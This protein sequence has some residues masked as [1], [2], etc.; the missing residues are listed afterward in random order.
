MKRILGI[1]LMMALLVTV[2]GCSGASVE[3]PE[4]QEMVVIEEAVEAPDMEEVTE[5]RQNTE[6]EKQGQADIFGKV[7]RIVGNE[8]TVQLV[9]MP[10]ISG[11]IEEG[12]EGGQNARA[13]GGNKQEPKYTGETKQIIIPVG[14]PIASRAREGQEILDLSD[15]VSGSMIM[16]WTDESGEPNKIQIMGAR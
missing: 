12:S 6:R 4:Q 10:E 7:S 2:V 14:V 5:I 9:E 8:V 15:I 11:N 1:G 16:L 13:A 3:V